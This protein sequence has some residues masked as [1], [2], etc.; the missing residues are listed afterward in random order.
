LNTS[1]LH[2]GRFLE[3]KGRYRCFRD[4]FRTNGLEFDR[5]RRFCRTH[6]GSGIRRDCNGCDW[7][8]DR[9]GGYWRVHLAQEVALLPDTT[10]AMALGACIGA[11]IAYGGAAGPLQATVVLQPTF[12]FY[13]VMPPI[14]FEAGFAINRPR[15]RKN[16][17]H[18]I[19][20]A[21][22][23]VLITSFLAAAIMYGCSLIY[24]GGGYDSFL[25]SLTFAAI[26]AATDLLATFQAV[27]VSPDLDSLIF[28]EAALN[29]TTSIILYKATLALTLS[30]ATINAAA[31][32]AAIGQ[33]FGIFFGAL[34]IGILFALILKFVPFRERGSAH[35]SGIVLGL[36][37]CAYLFSSFFNLSG[38]ISVL[39][40]GIVCSEHVIPNLSAA[41][42]ESIEHTLRS[43]SLL[44][45]NL[46]FSFLG[47]GFGAIT[48]QERIFDAAV[49]S[50][51]F[52]GTVVARLFTV[53]ILIP[54]CNPTRKR[55]EDRFTWRE[56]LFVA[57]SGLR[58]GVAFVLTL[59][60]SE[61][62][63][64]PTYYR[65][66]CLGTTLFIVFISVVFVGGATAR[67]M[68]ILKVKYHPSVAPI[69]VLDR[70]LQRSN[71]MA[72][73]EPEEEIE[74]ELKLD[75]AYAK[76]KRKFLAP[77]LI[78]KPT[79][80]MA[81]TNG[82]LAMETVDQAVPD[83]AE[84]GVRQPQ[85]VHTGSS[86]MT[87]SPSVMDRSFRRRWNQTPAERLYPAESAADWLALKRGNPTLASTD[88]VEPAIA[89]EH[90]AELAIPS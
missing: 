10:I 81:D 55:K 57:Y 3:R 85:R 17:V 23:G 78:R 31:I 5:W 1:N 12:F 41:G 65:A 46:L 63:A 59:E 43:I 18:I 73:Q 38:I 44:M 40:C 89:S 45:A 21:V 49:I 42:H 27:P 47:L 82:V 13:V 28:G 50:Y 30:G 90:L 24:P 66:L 34:G 60:L 80:V 22:L 35:E 54:L 67:T 52:I 70:T 16:F 51:T 20:T 58:G 15:F 84:P 26:Q 6:V 71:S 33:M 7:L 25:Q 61:T 83:T 88:R 69:E 76:L 75:T 14:M 56:I 37:Y 87:M 29:D 11:T 32:G 68:K 9:L 8:Y 39:F 79:V 72:F 86:A 62:T 4:A 64:L 48:N 53:S 2:D 19:V 77:A 74:A 36:A